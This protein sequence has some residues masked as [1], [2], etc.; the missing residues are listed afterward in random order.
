[1]MK[2]LFAL[3]FVTLFTLSMFASL[4]SAFYYGNDDYTRRTYYSTYENNG[5]IRTTNYDRTSESYWD[6]NE[7]VDRTTYVRET[8]EGNA[9]DSYYRRNYP[10][11]SYGRNYPWYQRHWNNRPYYSN[12]YP[13]NYYVLRY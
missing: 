10:Y 7:W 11:S 3:T 12:T 1:M 6:G 9:Y 13:R 2:K 8:R 4:S 5:Y